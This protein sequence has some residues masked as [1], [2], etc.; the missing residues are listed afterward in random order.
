MSDVIYPIGL[1]ADCKIKRMARVAADE[2]E[3]GS[4][5]TKA[6]WPLKYFKRRIEIQH[7]DLKYDEF[8][9]L[10]SFY[11]QR[12]GRYDSFWYRDNINRSGNYKVR[13]ANDID[14]GMSR[15]MLKLP[16][17][18]EEV[19]PIQA[20]PE[21]DEL[22]AAAGFTPALWYDANREYHLSHKGSS[23]YDLTGRTWDATLLGKYP[24]TWQ[25]GTFWNH[26]NSHLAQYQS[27]GFNTPWAKTAINI[28][29]IAAGQPACTLFAL[30]NHP[31]MASKQV[32]F[33]I[34]AMGT[35]NAMGLA[36]GADNKYQPWTGGSETWDATLFTNSPN[37]TWRSFAI[38]WAASSNVAKFY[39][40]AAL[41][42]TDTITRNYTQ[43][44]AAIGAAIDGTLLSLNTISAQH[45]IVFPG[46][47]TLAQV[48]AVHNLLGYQYGLSIV[49]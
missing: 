12:N 48:K 9:A 19:A 36:I 5:S 4:T 26:F 29:E 28:S 38:T 32:L 49:A 20:L 25:G 11:R 24:A 21:Y 44:P 23:V 46:E 39:V 30:A 17:Q 45:F 6:L 31:T 15:H 3:D 22:A 37:F 41:H 33:A 18:F 47:L 34:G 14:V 2:F 13:F 16:V 10:R 27:Y 1:V 35:G 8:L 40:N 42:G 7:A 43:G